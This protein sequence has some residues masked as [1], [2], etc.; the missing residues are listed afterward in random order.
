MG[1]GPSEGAQGPPRRSPAKEFN[2]IRRAH[3]PGRFMLPLPSLP[4]PA[5]F[6]L[7]EH[8]RCVDVCVD[9][10]ILLHERGL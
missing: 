6:P 8:A 9:V 3:S 4:A 10:E 2:K 1:N 7:A 5:M